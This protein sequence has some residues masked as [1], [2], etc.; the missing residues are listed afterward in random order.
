MTFGDDHI[1]RMRNAVATGNEQQVN[2]LLDDRIP[3]EL[4][5]RAIADESS[6]QRSEGVLVEARN[7]SEIAFE[8]R[9]AGFYRARQTPDAY[10]VADFLERRE[11]LV[12]NTVDENETMPVGLAKPE[13][14]EIGRLQAERICEVALTTYGLPT[15]GVG[16]RGRRRQAESTLSNRGYTREMPIFILRRWVSERFEPGHSPLAKIVQ[17][18]RTG[19]LTLKILSIDFDRARCASISRAPATF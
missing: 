8:Q 2:G 14:L 17:P 10:R 3:D 4:D 15:I 16:L 6:V 12:E 11:A 1:A 18:G 19:L 7:L 13:P 9:R 5:E